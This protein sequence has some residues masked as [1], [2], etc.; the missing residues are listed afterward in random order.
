MGTWRN[1]SVQSKKYTKFAEDHNFNPLSPKQYDL[2]AYILHLN[3]T[4]AAPG[5]VLNYISG[6]RTWVLLFGGATEGFDSYPVTLM[7]RGVQR[8]SNHVTVQAP[9]LS[10]PGLRRVVKHLK[11]LGPESAVI[12]AA[13]LIGY[14]ALLRQGNLVTSHTIQDQG[15]TLRRRDI[16]I[17]PEGLNIT[18]RT[19]KT[20]WRPGQAY[21]V[22]VPS[23]HRSSSCPLRAWEKYIALQNTHPDGPAF[24]LQGGAPLTGYVL[25]A[26]LR[27]SLAATGHPSPAAYTLH[28]L[29]RGGAQ[30]CAA[31]GGSLKEIMQL[32]AW[33]SEA[34]YT[35]VPRPLIR[36]RLAP[37]P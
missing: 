31:A 34:V 9:P 37:S 28:S 5:T 16:T 13:L 10:P 23:L 27:M 22:S 36:S 30:A 24:I 29:R 2:L 25:T 14:N 21:T 7:K 8:L 35:Y 17:T 4:L 20:R 1:K 3:D 12:I 33:S 26:A 19:T 11:T 32:G 6:A 18:V 15:H